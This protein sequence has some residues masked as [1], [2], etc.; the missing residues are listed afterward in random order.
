MRPF[1]RIIEQKTPSWAFPGVAAR[2]TVKITK[3][4]KTTPTA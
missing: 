3:T 1:D 2:A 4:T